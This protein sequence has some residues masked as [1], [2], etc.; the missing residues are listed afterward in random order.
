MNVAM[1]EK[2]WLF[3]DRLNVSSL[4]SNLLRFRS[5]VCQYLY[6]PGTQF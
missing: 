2:S 3:I 4:L 1:D 5:D 6:C